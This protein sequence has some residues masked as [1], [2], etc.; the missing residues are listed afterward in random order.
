M[1][2]W[3]NIPAR[4]VGL[5]LA[6]VALSLCAGAPAHAFTG[7][8]AIDVA[9]QKRTA[10]FVEPE[11]LK[12]SPRTVVIVL[13]GASN[14]SGRRIQSNLG[15]DEFLRA[16]GAVAVYPDA[17]EGGWNVTGGAG[18]DDAAFLRALA[19]KLVAD[20]VADKRKIFLMGASTGGMLALRVGCEGPD[21][22]AGV[23]ALIAG[24]PAKLAAGCKPPPLAFLL[25]NGTA[26]PLAP[27]QGGRANLA[28]FKEEIAS[29]EATLAPFAAANECSAQ[30]VA[31][32]FPDRDPTD[33]SRVVMERLVGCKHLV[34]LV[35]V[36]GGGH[37]LPGRPARSDR[38]QSVGALNRDVNVSGLIASFLRQ[39]QS[40]R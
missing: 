19:G 25:M 10:I 30:R 3:S 11:R 36:E 8:L 29:A 33:G 2:P 20:G 18:P 38:G 40:Q 17:L 35:R 5:M 26:N 21:Y 13:H 27:F 37:T 31:R 28:G 9:G 7:R 1:T 6:G 32:E 24:L 4:L 34:E 22:L 39:S 14:G 23:G 15:L 16:N 12:R